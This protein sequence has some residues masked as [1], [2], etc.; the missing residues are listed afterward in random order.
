[1]MLSSGGEIEE[2]LRLLRCYG[3]DVQVALPVMIKCLL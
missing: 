3:M 1:M 2:L